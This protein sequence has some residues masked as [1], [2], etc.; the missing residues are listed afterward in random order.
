MSEIVKGRNLVLSIYDND[1]ADYIVI[2][3]SKNVSLNLT[4]ETREVTNTFSSFFREYKPDVIT[5]NLSDDGLM[6]LDNFGYTKMTNALLTR[7]ILD[8]KFF[9]DNGIDGITYYT[10][11]AILTSVSLSGPNN[12]AASY[13]LTLQG[14]GQLGVSGVNPTNPSEVNEITYRASGGETNFVLPSLISQE[15]LYM[16]R[17]GIDVEDILT[18]GTPSTYQVFFD[19]SNGQVDVNASN[20]LTANE[21]IR[22]LYKQL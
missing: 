1:I 20:P 21:F 4:L 8:I 11:L 6:I 3:C 9:V 18:V 2:A 17:G 22:I 14:S 15:M 19:S 13:S 7:Q 16:S 12:D 5:W 10:G